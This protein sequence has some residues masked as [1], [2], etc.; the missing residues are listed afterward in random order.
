MGMMDIGPYSRKRVY[1][2][3]AEW[4]VPNEYATSLYNYL[5]YGFSPGGF[6]TSV[7]A[8]DWHLAV[9]RSHP[10]NTIEALKAATGWIH[11]HVPPEARGSYEAVN[12]WCRLDNDARKAI[13]LE[14]NLVLPS[15][16]EVIKALKGEST[17]EPILW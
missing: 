17:L 13:L 1:E 5:V 2:T 7:L 16:T 11:D 14:R 10:S 4:R 6:F 3:F 9:M 12:A 15:K 8:N